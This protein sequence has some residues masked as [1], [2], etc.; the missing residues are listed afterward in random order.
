MLSSLDGWLAPAPD[1]ARVGWLTK[2]AYAHRG[3]HGPGA[4]ENSPTAFERA[5]EAGLGIECDVQLTADGRAMVFHDFEL[6]RLT[7]ESGPVAKRTAAELGQIGLTGSGDRIPSL[8]RLLEQIGGRVPLLV[9][10]KTRRETPID[11]LCRAVLQ[12]LGA[13]AGPH[14]V[15][16]FDPRVGHWFAG[17]SP[18]TV[19]GLVVSEADS[20]A[21][22]RRLSLWRARP[23]FLAYDVRNLPSRFAE[24]QRQRGLP[25]LTWT[26]R[27]AAL[28]ERAAAC[29]ATPIAEGEGVAWAQRPSTSSG[30]TE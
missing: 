11:R 10:V 15:M 23:D 3:L 7:D 18:V 17:H 5:I 19:R 28:A 9:E 25:L 30:R 16:S 6:D 2:G 1:P 26:V 24:G 22:A 27:S 20:G 4:V 14:A 12:D 13:Y 21:A 8:R 29:A